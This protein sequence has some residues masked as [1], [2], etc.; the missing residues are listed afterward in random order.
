MNICIP[1]KSS[2]HAK[3]YNKNCRAYGEKIRSGHKIQKPFQR[4]TKK[5]KKKP[6]TSMVSNVLNAYGIHK[7]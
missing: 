5:K 3:L 6:K 2:C 7:H 1:K 4:C